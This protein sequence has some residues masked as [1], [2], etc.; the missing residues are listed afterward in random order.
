MFLTLY[1]SFH[2][3][4]KTDLKS[5][6]VVNLPERMFLIM[7]KVENDIFYVIVD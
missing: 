4:F 6:K 1:Q 2:V 5:K 7:I 3:L